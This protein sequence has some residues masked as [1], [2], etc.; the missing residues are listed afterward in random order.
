MNTFNRV[1]R[2]FILNSYLYYISVCLGTVLIFTGLLSLGSKLNVTL[3]MLEQQIVFLMVRCQRKQVIPSKPCSTTVS[4]FGMIT[5]IIGIGID[6]A[7]KQTIIS[8]QIT[9][10]ISKAFNVKRRCLLKHRL[11]ILPVSI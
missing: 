4:P 10:L 2:R 8:Q 3:I 5:I 7:I 9:R 1:S 6:H 11:F